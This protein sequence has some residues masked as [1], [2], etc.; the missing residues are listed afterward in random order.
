MV[1]EVVTVDLASVKVEALVVP[2]HVQNVA[3]IVGQPFINNENVTVVIRNNQVRLFNKNNKDI[4]LNFNIFILLI[5]CNYITD[6]L[7]LN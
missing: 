7:I 2:D 5:C 3:I 1:L 4:I 6:C